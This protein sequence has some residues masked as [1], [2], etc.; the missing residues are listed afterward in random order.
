MANTIQA[1]FGLDISPLRAAANRA[2]TVGRNL[3]RNFSRLASGPLAQV[4]VAFAAIG[5]GTGV[6][7]GIKRA[8][9][10][11]G[12]LTDLRGKTGLAVKQIMTLQQAAKDSGIEDIT[13][14][15]ARMQKSIA[16]ATDSADPMAKSLASLG[17]MA[18]ELV[19]Q[20]ALDQIRAIGG[21]IAAI[22]NPTLRAAK[23]MELFGK[24]GADLLPLFEDS[25]AL[26]TAAQSLGRQAELLDR[27]A[28]AF[29]TVS[30]RLGL[31]E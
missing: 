15:V 6:A 2:A 19:D 28:A 31:S 20:S 21:R 27:N 13:G 29:D 10:L 11:G 30:D 5:G 17:L 9:D 8:Y 16:A 26:D 22:Q 4:G 7:R 12:A 14:H 18:K 25:S 3:G 24:S 23:A 1:S